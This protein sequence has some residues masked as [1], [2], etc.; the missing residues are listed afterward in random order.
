MPLAI[1]LTSAFARFLR[2][3]ADHVDPATPDLTPEWRKQILVEATRAPFQPRAT[4]HDGDATADSDER[5]LAWA[6]ERG[7]FD[8]DERFQVENEMNL[9]LEPTAQFQST[10]PWAKTRA[11]LISA[12]SSKCARIA[13]FLIVLATLAY[14]AWMIAR[15]S[16]RCGSSPVRA[17]TARACD[18]ASVHA[19]DASASSKVVTSILY[20]PTV[21]GYLSSSPGALTRGVEVGSVGF[22]MLV[23][24]GGASSHGALNAA[25]ARAALDARCERQ[26]NAAHLVG[27]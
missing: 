7:A 16:S 11:I 14:A 5:R 10:T 17:V 26:L 25:A 18:R 12:C 8:S 21:S 3:V 15:D 1:P 4:F 22:A 6:T 27:A 2:Q 19:V 13:V 24:S 9:G 23:S 20:S